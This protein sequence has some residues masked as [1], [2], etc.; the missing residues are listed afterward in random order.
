[1]SG[2][3]MNVKV[4]AMNLIRYIWDHV[5]ESGR[6]IG[7]LS[8]VGSIIDAPSEEMADSLVE[9]LERRDLVTIG[10]VNRLLDGTLLLNVNISLESNTRA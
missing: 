9:E 5:S 10:D 1:M 2:T 6:P 3:V 7:Q 8:G 4:L